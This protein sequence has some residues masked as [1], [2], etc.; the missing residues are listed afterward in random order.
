MT[1]PANVHNGWKAVIRQHVRECLLLAA[2]GPSAS[3]RP[4]GVADIARALTSACLAM[5]A[6]G[7]KASQLPR[8]RPQPKVFRIPWREKETAAATPRCKLMGL[9][10]TRVGL[11]LAKR[12]LPLLAES[13]MLY[14]GLPVRKHPGLVWG[15]GNPKADHQPVRFRMSAFDPEQTFG[16]TKSAGGCRDDERRQLIT[17]R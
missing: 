13:G 8:P 4:W 2:S 6:A 16:A 14:P 9:P 10:P 7:R 1:D 5:D 12:L 11:P 3:G 17:S 15:G